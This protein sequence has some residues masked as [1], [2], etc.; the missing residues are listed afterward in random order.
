MSSSA[1]IPF[2]EALESL[3]SAA[4][5]ATM[6]QKGLRLDVA[7]CN[8]QSEFPYAPTVT[9]YMAYSK[10]A[11][12]ILFEVAESHTCAVELA[13]NGRV[14]EDSCVELFIANPVG[15]GYFNFE[16]NAIKTLLAAKR[17]S[18]TNAEHFSAD[19]LAM[20]VRH[21]SF[22]HAPVDIRQQNSWWAGE[23]I[24][25]SLLGVESMPESLSVNIYKCGDNLLQPHYLSWSPITLDKPNFHCP[26]FFGTLIAKYE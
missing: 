14:W 8:W 15:E 17:L 5:R 7:C 26:E 16:M 20:I 19:S 24:P 12:A 4:F 21:G 13:D 3:D 25:F 23:V 18:R 22:D 11:I 2:V 1:F 6:T 10:S 9:A